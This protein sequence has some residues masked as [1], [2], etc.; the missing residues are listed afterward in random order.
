MEFLTKIALAFEHGG[1]WMWPILL[2]QIFSIAII[3]ERVYA[4]Y[5][6]RKLDQTSIALGFEEN[7][8]RGEMD[9]LISKAQ[10]MMA[11]NPVARAVAAGGIAAKNFGGK[12]EIQGKMD[13][14]LLEENAHLDR[15]TAFLSMLGNV[16][17]L[18]G[19]LG[20]IT[21]MIKSFAAVAF[22]N[23]AEKASL[24][25]AGISE[26]MNATAYGL[27][28][29]IP[30]LVAYAILQNR[31]NRLAEDLNQGGLKVFNWLSYSYEP[32]T[33]YQV[34]T[35]KADRQAEVNS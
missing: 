16:A 7:I 33:S 11:Q 20:T 8:R 14:V 24:L 5:I 4:L 6:R 32:I 13:E 27:I 26:A 17:T 15:R 31:A 10:A 9:N 28:T 22:A 30:A 29:A 3:I 19:L 1:F 12:D 2:I 21:G 25:S 18:T 23:P 34:K 35:S